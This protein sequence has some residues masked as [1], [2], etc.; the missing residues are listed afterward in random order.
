ML[1]AEAAILVHFETI[2][3]IL[4]VLLRL[5]VSLLALAARQCDFYSHAIGTSL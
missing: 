4:L 1:A 5:V 2:G 3:I